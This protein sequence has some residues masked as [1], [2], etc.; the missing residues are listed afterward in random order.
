MT[1]A[2]AATCARLSAER[3]ARLAG[4]VLSD[5]RALTPLLTRAAPNTQHI[6][7][8]ALDS[9]EAL[10]RNHPGRTS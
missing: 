4:Y 10:N 3:N 5:L 7:A 2:I 9:A 6:L 8:R 1:A